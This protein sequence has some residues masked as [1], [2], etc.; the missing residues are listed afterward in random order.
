M[1]VHEE[2]LAMCI[3]NPLEC[4]APESMQAGTVRPIIQF[5]YPSG[6]L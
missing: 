4:M 3:P 1:V 2:S 6:Q 5:P